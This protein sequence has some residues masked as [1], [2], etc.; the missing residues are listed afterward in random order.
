M[1]ALRMK[2]REQ[3]WGW[4]EDRVYGL[5]IKGLALGTL[6]LLSTLS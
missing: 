3:L 2:V 5:L 4:D 6:L 1:E